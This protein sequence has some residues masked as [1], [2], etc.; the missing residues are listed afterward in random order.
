MNQFAEYQCY[1]DLFEPK[2]AGGFVSFALNSEVSL[3]RGKPV[4]TSISAFHC[5]SDMGSQLGKLPLAEND[6]LVQGIFMIAGPSYRCSTEY[7]F[8]ILREI[9]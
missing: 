2:M 7:Y 4:Q 3:K 1:F 9:Y 6:S 8:A 5:V